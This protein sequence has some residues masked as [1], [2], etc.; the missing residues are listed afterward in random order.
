MKAERFSRNISKKIDTFQ[1]DASPHYVFGTWNSNCFQ[2]K[3][4]KYLFV[5]QISKKEE[6]ISAVFL[7]VFVVVYVFVTALRPRCNL[8][9]VAVLI[10]TVV[11][12][13]RIVSSSLL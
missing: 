8:V 12:V 9:F 11:V 2:K 7:P 13:F 5:A 3:L 1:S 4:A 10:V 6:S